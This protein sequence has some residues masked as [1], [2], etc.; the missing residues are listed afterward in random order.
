MGY[1]SSYLMSHVKPEGFYCIIMY[2]LIL[3]SKQ[4]QNRSILQGVSDV[5]TLLYALHRITKLL[6]LIDKCNIKC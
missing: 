5:L 3:H 6:N 4:M 2:V 1:T